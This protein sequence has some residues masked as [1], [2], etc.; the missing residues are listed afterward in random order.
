MFDSFKDAMDWLNDAIGEQM[1]YSVADKYPVVASLVS[2]KIEEVAKNKK[3]SEEQ[4][5][6]EACELAQKA[7]I[8]S[9]EL[10]KVWDWTYDDYEKDMEAEGNEPSE[11]DYYELLRIYSDDFIDE[12]FDEDL[13]RAM[14]DARD[15]EWRDEYD[16]KRK[17]NQYL[18]DLDSYEEDYKEVVKEESYSLILEIFEE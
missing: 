1:E 17:M 11:D 7:I 4:I 10:L 15:F 5:Q 16:F 2:W 14:E 12:E 6:K 13:K 8:N 18:K 3:K 9:M